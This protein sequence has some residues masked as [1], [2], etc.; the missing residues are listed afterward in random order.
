MYPPGNPNGNKGRIAAATGRNAGELARRRM[1]R[2]ISG[3]SSNGRARASIR[4]AAAA[5]VAKT[6]S[7]RF[8]FIV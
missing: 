3:G 6:R 7:N 2:S 5:D 8:S 1:R 4:A